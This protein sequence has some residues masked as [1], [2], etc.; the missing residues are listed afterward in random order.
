MIDRIHA[1]VGVNVLTM[2]TETI[3]PDQTVIV[4]DGRI[5][6]IDARTAVTVPVE[7]VLIAGEGKYLMPALA[8]MHIHLNDEAYLP[9]LLWRP[10]SPPCATWPGSQSISNGAM[11]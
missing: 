6:E 11:R 5:V 1:F 2:E 4:V 9:H 3:L 8:D 10:A 7:S